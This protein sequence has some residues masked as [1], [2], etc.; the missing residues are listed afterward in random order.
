MLHEKQVK[1]SKNNI[2]HAIP[3]IAACARISYGAAQAAKLS[4]GP[5]RSR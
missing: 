3:D 1:S 4:R 2:F 5:F